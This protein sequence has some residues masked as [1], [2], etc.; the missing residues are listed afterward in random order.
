MSDN[1]SFAFLIQ[2]Y[3][4][5]HFSA[6]H[7]KIIISQMQQNNQQQIQLNDYV[8]KSFQMG[9]VFKDNVCYQMYH[10]VINS[11]VTH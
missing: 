5:K 9:R 8:V 3:Y 1:I 10:A 7:T 2:R 4:C 11:H 6:I